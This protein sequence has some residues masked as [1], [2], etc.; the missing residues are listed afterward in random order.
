MEPEQNPLLSYDEE[1]RI[2][3][4]LA[5]AAETDGLRAPDRVER[6]LVAAIRGR[7]R[8]QTFGRVAIAGAIAAA[9]FAVLMYSLPRPEPVQRAERPA[10]PRVET[11]AVAVPPPAEQNVRNPP[12]PRRK[13]LRVPPLVVRTRPVPPRTRPQ[14]ATELAEF[15]PVGTWQAYEPM[16]R[17]SI[18]RVRLP[19]ATL[20]G[21]G[22]PVSADRWNESIPADVLLGE[23]GTMRA[24]R[25]VTT[26]Q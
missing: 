7:K 13:P 2:R 17:G 26:S 25:F 8:R 5:A 11:A 16:E 10:A 1:Q 22:I 18:V 12:G 14:P 24:V 9:V 19:K 15:I 23:D 4:V 3:A 6:E 21:L 20:P